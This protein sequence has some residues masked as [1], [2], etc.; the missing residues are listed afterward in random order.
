MSNYFYDMIPQEDFIRLS[1][2]PTIPQLLE[3]I[4]ADYAD[5]P[6]VTENKITTTYKQL[7][8]NVGKRRAFINSL[9]LP[10][11]STISILERNSQNAI[12]LYLAVMSAGYVVNMLPAQL[13]GKALFG[14]LKKFNSKALFVRDEFNAAVKEA[15]VDIPVYTSDSTGNEFEPVSADIKKETEAAIYFTG[16]T[17][18]VPKGALLTH[19]NLMRGAYNGIFMPGKAIGVHRYITFL[20]FS[21]VFGSIRGL[22]ACLYTG[23]HLFTCTDMKM[24]I[25]SIPF[26][27]PTC[28]VLV[29]GLCEIILGL[30]KLQGEQFLGGCLKTIIAGAANVPSRLIEDLDK[31]GI[32]VLQGYGLTESANLVSGN[33]DYRQK[34]ESV[35]QIYPEQESKLVNGELWL[36]GD[37]I[38]KG[39]Y[40][41]PEK[42]AECFEDGWFKT[43]DLAKIDQDGFLYI[44]GRIKNLI[45]L[46]NGE[47]VSPESIEDLFSNNHF[48]KDCLVQKVE[49]NG[50][51]I[52]GIQ[53]LP[54]TTAFM[55]ASQA[56][57][58]EKI[59]DIVDQVNS[60]L[61]S[62]MQL[63][64]VV[65]RTEDFK[66]TGSM[67]IQR[68]Q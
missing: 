28:L 14:S 10:K 16:G 27:K 67:K 26:I 49:K 52:L 23:S 55:G 46:D 24:G 7:A 11:G 20:P 33:A 34:P 58:E 19:G 42:A 63:R 31:F 12:E 38:F 50:Q 13:A 17:T 57:I 29:P 4:E 51:N 22:L 21:H 5:M 2:L 25:G 41:D 65:V 45:L 66:R 44:V 54:N 68:N 64:S 39:Y 53:I 36:K 15:G 59:K 48:V 9:G 56:E 32:S 8:E 40:G 35:G 47:N 6:A 3:K 60:T 1:Y 62:Y 18:G 43:G 30:A 37:H 61:P